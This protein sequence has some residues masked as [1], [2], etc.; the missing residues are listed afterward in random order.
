M[1]RPLSRQLGDFARAMHDTDIAQQLFGDSA[2]GHSAYANNA[3]FNR[4]D[5]LAE[6][7]PVVRQLVGDD[8]FGAM[9]RAHARAEPSRSGDLHAYGERFADFIATFAPA[10][11]L[12]YLAD[13]AKLDWLCHRAYYAPDH[14]LLRL[15]ALA[16]IPAEQHGAL[17]WS[18]APSAALM[19]SRW[20][21]A[22]LWLAHESLA[23]GH[24]ASFPSPDQGGERVLVY[25]DAMLKVRVRRLLASDAAFLQACAAGLPMAEALERALDEDM[26]FDLGLSLQRWVADQVVSEFHLE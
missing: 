10:Q 21:V 22:S 26:D 3:L 9:A 18:L 5:A 20:P 11:E 15:E 19:Q 4:A 8:F 17:V 7:F 16:D 2:R 12:P 1:N 6:A 23:Q 25:R 24:E 13:C 14:T